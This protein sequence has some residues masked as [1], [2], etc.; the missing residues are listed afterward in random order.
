[1]SEAPPLSP[2]GGVGV[3]GGAE[4]GGDQSPQSNVREQDRFL[5]IANIG[6]IMKKALPANGKIAKEAKDTVQECVSE[7]ISFVTSEASEKCQ[8]EKRKT[9]N[10]DDLLWALATLGFEDYIDPLK[11]YLT[12]YRELEGDTRV[13]ARVG[14]G[15]AN[16]IGTQLGSNTEFVHQGSFAHGFNF[17]N[18]QV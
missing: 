18:S 6:R 13:S 9:V 16:T 14:D 8:K 2:G 17:A 12:R 15:A 11:G 10:G 3:G 1:M 5:P 4:S 7:F